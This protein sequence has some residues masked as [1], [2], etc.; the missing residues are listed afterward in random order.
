MPGGAGGESARREGGARQLGGG[1][2]QT[3]KEGKVPGS[4]VPDKAKEG[5]Q[6]E[7]G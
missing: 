7:E 3:G 6:V 4:R 1:W 5:M 2:C